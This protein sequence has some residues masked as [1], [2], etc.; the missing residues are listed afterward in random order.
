MIIFTVVV[1]AEDVET[2]K[3]L[4]SQGLKVE[5]IDE[6]QPFV[7]QPASVLGKIYSQ[8]GTKN[9][10]R[11]FNFGE[12][13]F[14]FR[15][16]LQIETYRTT[17]SRRRFIKYVETVYDRKSHFCIYAASEKSFLSI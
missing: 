16:K 4:F 5:T 8:L 9:L 1:L 3:I 14:S 15:K 11:N 17:V 7:V 10:S 12:T 2:Q 13:S 6:V